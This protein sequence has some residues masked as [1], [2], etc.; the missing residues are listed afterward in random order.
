MTSTAFSFPSTLM[1]MHSRVNSSITS[2]QTQSVCREH[3]DFPSVVRAILDEI[4]G[5][6]T[7]GIP[8]AATVSMSP[9]VGR[10]D[11]TVQLSHAFSA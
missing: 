5:P 7:V 8:K 2:A 3:S 1:A 6:H 9:F 4:V 11:R 10:R